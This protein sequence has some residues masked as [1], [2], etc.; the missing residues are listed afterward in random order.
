M[1]QA[2]KKLRKSPD[3]ARGVGIHTIDSITG[4]K[5]VYLAIA[6]SPIARH[7]RPS[8]ERGDTGPQIAKWDSGDA[9]L[10]V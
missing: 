10:E 3:N 5:F 4:P 8:D 2:G 1:W 6:Y 7:M 9:F